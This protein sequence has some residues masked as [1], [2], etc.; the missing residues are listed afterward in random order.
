MRSVLTENGPHEASLAWIVDVFQRGGCV[1]VTRDSQL[2]S[3]MHF[4]LL[5]V[6]V[7]ATEQKRGR[8]QRA[9][10]KRQAD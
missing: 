2:G 9:G 6:A 7:R 1:C 10:E 5:R 3:C 4:G 8:G